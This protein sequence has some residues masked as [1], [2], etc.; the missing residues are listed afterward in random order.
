MAQV[1]V[2]KLAEIVGAPVDRLLTQMKEAG[3]QHTAAEDQVSD[4]EKQTLLAY[5]KRTHGDNGST[6]RK[7]TLKRK[8]TTQLKTSTGQ[9]RGAKTVNVEV[10]KKRTYVKRSAIEAEQSAEKLEAEVKQREE[11]RQLEEARAAEEAKRQE[12]ERKEA[13]RQAE[14]QR[15]EEEKLRQQQQGEQGPGESESGQ[16]QQAV[17]EE[18]PKKSEGKAKK[19]S[20]AERQRL[21]KEER[22]DFKSPEKKAKKGEKPKV[23][24]KKWIEEVEEV[25]EEEIIHSPKPKRVYVE[26][27]LAKPTKFLKKHAFS[28]PTAPVQKEV[29]IPENITVGELAQRMSVKAADVIKALMKMGVMTT[30]NQSIDQETAILVVEDMGH[31]YR[32][33][34]PKDIEQETLA[35]VVYEGE[36]VSRAPVVT[37]MGHVD[38]GKTSLLDYIRK[39][40]VTAGESGGITQHIGAY[41]VKTD[42]GMVCFLD[43]PGHAAFTAM[44]ARGAQATDVVILGVAADDGVMPQTEEAV[45]HARAAGVPLVVAVNKMDK[46]AADPDRVKNELA[47]KDVIPEEWGGDTQFIPVSAH[48]GQGVDELLDAVLLQA[49]M[50]E[51]TA[52]AKGPAKGVVVEA[53]LDKGRGV[54]ATLL[55]QNGT[56]QQGDTILAGKTVVEMNTPGHIGGYLRTQILECAI[57]L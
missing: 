50:L 53:R 30:I 11:E 36:A 7:I 31:K 3:L 40:K 14:A 18:Q 19:L 32:L 27:K 46:E 16:A 21:E 47:G 24:K 13:E 2:A 15:I 29:A 54:V 10:R 9:G 20:E 55:V 39:T 12:E 41:H 8:V 25:Y 34:E 35:E 49:E 48:T 45:Q 57:D 44:R 23:A 17:V 28:R 38:H 43:T 33:E 26:P 22:D 6:P 51:L 5:L 37:V 42:K 52:V 1:T 4:E 56:L